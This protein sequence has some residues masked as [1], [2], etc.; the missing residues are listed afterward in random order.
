MKD[1]LEFINTASIEELANAP[2]VTLTLA[3][4]IV[5]ARP[6]SSKEECKKVKGISTKRLQSL[7]DLYDSIEETPEQDFAIP[8]AEVSLG[9]DFPARKNSIGKIILRIFIAIFILGTMFAV[10]YFGIPWFK[11]NVLNQVQINTERVSEVASQQA[12]NM[13]KQSTEIAVLQD[14]VLTLEA[15]TD[16]I[17][18]S[19]LSITATLK[20]LDEMQV[21]LQT[22]IDS[23]KSEISGQ[24]AEQ[25][26]LTRAIELLLR[27][28]LYMSQNNF[29]LAQEDA[30]TA[31]NLLYSLVSTISPDQSGALK[32]VISRLD[33]ALTNMESYPVIAVYDL[34]LAWRLLVDGLPNVPEMVITPV[35]VETL[36]PTE[37]AS[38]TATPN[39]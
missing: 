38:T 9:K 19:I 26:T 30:V 10:Y 8:T 1:F 23:Q 16:N 7:Q 35:I 3:K 4:G 14:R 11:D 27:S 13:E 2:G 15:R 32:I 12:D 25:L 36:T 34:D 22:N 33:T 21:A 39:P 31:R 17:D 18:Q 20:Q 28:R 5:S 24:V 37:T 29:G 6:F